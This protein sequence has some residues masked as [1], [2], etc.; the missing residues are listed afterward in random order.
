MPK[1]KEVIAYL[2][3][4]APPFYQESYDN[5]GLITGH[6]EQEVSGILISL[7]AI[8]SVVEEAIQRN[9]N[10][11]VAHHPIVFRGLK[12][13]TGKHY[14]ERT[15]IK[16]IKQDIA[17][18]A[19][20][21]NLDHVYRGVN[22]KISQRLGLQELRILDPKP[23]TLHKLVTFVPL[24]QAESLLHALSQAGAGHIGNY[25][26]CSFQVT[27]TGTFQPNEQ[28]NPHI[29]ERGKLEQVE[30][31]RIEVIF[32][33]YLTAKVLAAMREAHPYE[34]VAYYVQTLVNDNQEVGSGMVGTLPKPM[35]E[36]AFLQFLKDAMQVQVIRHTQWLGQPIRTVAV[37]GGAGSFLLGKAIR[38]KADVFI[39]SDFKYHEFFEADRRILVADIGHYESE[40]FTKDLLWE[41]LSEKF[42]N[43]AV[44]LAKANTNPVFYF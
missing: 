14:V 10:L 20:H 33:A 11:I 16:A 28:A 35:E 15:V 29:G 42:V 36:K 23:A 27:G 26:N 8:E 17:I 21:T 7:D 9:C 44:H 5:S 38:Q 41:L 40:V 39:T 3:Q 22:H 32:P 24:P 43:F 6:P 19:I 31:K 18:Y 4:I 34:E 37:C 1:I 2:E 12:S 25:Q 30:E 13:L